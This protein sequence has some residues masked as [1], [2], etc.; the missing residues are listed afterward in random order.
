MVRFAPENLL[1]EQLTLNN[2]KAEVSR[3]SEFVKEYLGKLPIEK[4]VAAGLRLALEESVVNVIDYAYPEGVTG[5]VSV[6]ADSNRRE[7]RFTVQDHGTPFDPT[8]VLEADT[9]LDAQKRPIGGLGILLTRK[10]MD[11]ISYEHRDGQN[12][13]ILTKSIV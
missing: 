4:K 2:D 8:T 11:S 1:R 7:V 3:L 12:V 10:L 5:S 9:T 6:L 13:L